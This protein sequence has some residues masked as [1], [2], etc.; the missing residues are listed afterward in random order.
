[1][2]NITSAVLLAFILVVVVVLYSWFTNHMKNVLKI[3][4][5]KV[6]QYEA[7]NCKRNIYEIETYFI[8]NKILEYLEHADIIDEEKQVVVLTDIFKQ[9]TSLI[10][11][12]HENM[13]ETCIEFELQK[14]KKMHFDEKLILLTTVK[15]NRFQKI[16]KQQYKLNCRSFLINEKIKTIL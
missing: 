12:F 13:C 7:D 9:D 15:N 16:L 1:M 6:V 3:K 10:L 4:E 14:L 8:E 11:Y 2:K 5:G